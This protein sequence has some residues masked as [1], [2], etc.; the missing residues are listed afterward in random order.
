MSLFEIRQYQ[1]QPGRMA[2]W[3]E[4]METKIVPFITSK[5][6][7]VTAMF[8]SLEDENRFIWLRRFENEAAKQ[9]LYE[10]VYQSEEWQTNFKP[11]VRSLV[12]VENAIVQNVSPTTH[13]SVA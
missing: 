3:V 10:A 9:E 7:E 12:D 4:F 1:I 13:S 2:E 11:T 8:E 5:G 6:M